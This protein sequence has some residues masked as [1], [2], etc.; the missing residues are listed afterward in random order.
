MPR[1]YAA[2]FAA[3]SV[4]AAQ[5][6]FEITAPSTGVVRLMGLV[7]GQSSDYGDAQAEGLSLTIVRGYTTSGSGGS[8]VTPSLLNS[9]NPAA[10][11]AVEANNTTVATTGTA[12]TLHADAW[13]VQAGYQLWWP[14]EVRPAARNSERIVVRSTAPADA[15]TLS[16][17]LYF[18][19]E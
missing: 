3:V 9:S 16:G 1:Q 8:A 15:I 14:P 13:N 5:D 2:T 19:E 10:S 7:L 11:A 18:E 6:V 4:T 12:V 17:T